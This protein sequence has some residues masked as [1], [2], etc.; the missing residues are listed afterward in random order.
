V[1]ASG[2]ARDGADLFARP[3]SLRWPSERR[4]F[5]LTLLFAPTMIGIVGVIVRET[6]TNQEIA[7]FIVIA[8]VY[9]TLVRGRLLG[10]SIRAHEGQLPHLHRVADRCAR[11]LGVQMPHVFVRED[12]FVCCTSMGLG[13]PYSIAISSQWLPHF[14]EDELEF[15]VGAEMA[16]IAAGH[17]RVSSLFSASGHE[18]PFV[19]LVAGAWMRRTEYTAD[20]VGML[21]CGSLDAA[22]RAIFKCSFHPL[23]SQAS[24]I[25]FADQRRELEVDPGLRL[26]EWLGESP[27][28]V[29]RLRELKRFH[30]SELYAIWKAEFDAR[31]E[32]VAQG[33]AQTPAPESPV[34]PK[35][36]GFFQRSLA[37]IVDLILVSSIASGAKLATVDVSDADLKT[38]LFQGPGV[39]MHVLNDWFGHSVQS[40]TQALEG[41]GTFF[42]I[43]VYSAVLVAFT[44]RT[45]GM[46]VFGMRVVRRDLGRVSAGRAVWRY[47]LAMLSV[48][49]VIPL[50][51]DLFSGRML[52]DRFSGTRVVKG[53]TG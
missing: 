26:G 43:F 23:A 14:E 46:L 27:Y 32:L 6:F 29:N 30:E 1:A 45:F 21:C 4:V 38:G 41:V 44:G 48:L 37:L 40:F 25:A 16:H 20:R 51:V 52:H 13:P 9:V 31:R 50:F 8:M 18:N 39:T 19:A 35:D 10:T 42:L 28:A 33:S 47:L 22:T 15:L 36:V 49:T 7:F 5:W 3:D 12:L 24:F 2:P 34:K 17:T 11:M 53:G